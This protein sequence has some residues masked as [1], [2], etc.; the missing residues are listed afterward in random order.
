[1]LNMKCFSLMFALLMGAMAIN[2]QETEENKKLDL[3]F[4]GFIKGDMVYSTAGVNSFG[5]ATLGAPQVAN[6]DEQSAI[7]FT[8]QHTR[9]G[10]KS[11]V[12]EEYKV[13][14]VIEIDFFGNAFDAN[15]KPRLRLGYASL[16]KGG[17]EVRMGQQWDLFSANNAT[18][19]NTNGNMWF[20]GNYGF[21]RAQ[22][23]LSYKLDVENIFPMFQLSL[24]EGSREDTGLGKDNLSGIP[25][26]QARVSGKIM[27][28]FTVGVSYVNAQFLEKGTILLQDYYFKFKTS[29][30]GV[31]INLPI[32]QYLTLVGEFN[33]GTNLNNSNLFS[34]GGNHTFAVNPLN[35]DV[36]Q[37]DKKS[38]GFW[39]NASSKLTD[40]LTLT[41]GYGMDQNKSE[42]YTVNAIEKNSVFYTNLTLPI[43]HGFAFMLEYQNISTTQITG[44]DGNGAITDSKGNKANVLGVAA[45]VSF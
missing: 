28:K 35:G 18:T 11:T 14:G 38:Q 43:K 22:L 39:L 5:A 2:A 9:L 41:L 23:Q 15:T 27:N 17:L 31:D 19:N 13:G 3:K 7:G 36:T 24:G 45:R 16:Q 44:V 1:M 29:G 12:G 10:L 32:H 8:A 33:T 20:A 6:G 4:Y 34:V 30:F 26:I 21:R 37:Y 25:M 42:R 40:W